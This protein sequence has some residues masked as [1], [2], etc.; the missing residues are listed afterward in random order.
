MTTDERLSTGLPAL[1]DVLDGGLV[2]N[3]NLLLRGPPGAGKTLFGLHFLAEGVENGKTALYIN[4]GEPTE[5]V[6]ETAAHFGL[7]P[8]DVHFHDL[9]PSQGEFDDAET[10]TL[11]ASAEVEQPSFVEAMRAS[12]E[13]LQPDRVL[14]DPITE[15]RYLT[16]D[17]RQFRKRILSFLDYLKANDATV[18]LTSQAAETTPDD[19]LQFL[20]DAVITL[21]TGLEGRSLFVSKFRGS[22]FQ[23]GRHTYEITDDGLTV[24]PKLQPSPRETDFAKEKLSSGVP[25]LD[26]LLNGG[27]ETGTVTF[28]S[29]PTGAGKTTTGLQFLKEAVAG[30]TESVLYSFEESANTIFERSGAINLPIE[31]MVEREQLSIVEILPDQYAVDEFTAMVRSAVEDD[32]AELVMID[33]IQGFKS[34]LRA[35]G[36]PPDKTLLRLGRYLRSRGVSTIVTNEVH[37][38]TGEFRATEEQTSNLADNIVFLRH[39]EF[40]GEIRKVIGVLKMRTS[41]FERTLRQLEITE[42]GLKV[43]E[44][45][46]GMRGILTGTPEL[47]DGRPGSTGID[48]D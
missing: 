17:D 20:T 10:Y 11:F 31:A 27:L 28:L 7:H 32:G 45:L 3:R 24:W 46:P 15:L 40:D 48:D 22:S 41:D 18:V 38:V 33:G 43:G 26:S 34:N 44:P 36:V 47:A 13:D 39:V 5:Y 25:E 2:R 9:S 6:K 16:T 37:N 21:E 8:D 30:G 35:A 42:H 12:I 29:G 14:L 19:D 23:R 4:L 1:D